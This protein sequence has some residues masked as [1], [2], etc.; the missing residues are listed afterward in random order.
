MIVRSL[1]LKNEFPFLVFL[2]LFISQFV[3]PANKLLATVAKDVS[4]S[5]S[6]SGHHAILLRTHWYIHHIVEKVSLPVSTVERPWQQLI[7]VGQ[8]AAAMFTTVDAPI[9]LDQ[10]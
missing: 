2:S 6:A 7:G 8:M 3:F 5:V 4:Y 10:I 9:K 1:P